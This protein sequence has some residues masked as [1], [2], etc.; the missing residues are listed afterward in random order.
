MV[1]HKDIQYITH[2]IGCLLKG[3][4]DIL[5]FDDTEEKIIAKYNYDKPILTNVQIKH[6]VRNNSHYRLTFFVNFTKEHINEYK[7]LL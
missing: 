2:R 6:T 4:A 7:K 1:I 5:F 3:T